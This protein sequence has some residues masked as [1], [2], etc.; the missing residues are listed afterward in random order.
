M[1]SFYASIDLRWGRHVHQ[2]TEAGR[3]SAGNGRSYLHNATW[4]RTRLLVGFTGSRRKGRDW[5]QSWR[6]RHHSGSRDGRHCLGEKTRL[7]RTPNRRAEILRAAEIRTDQPIGPKADVNALLISVLS[8]RE[9][10]S[11]IA[12]KHNAAAGW[13]KT[14]PITIPRQI[15]STWLGSTTS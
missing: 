7:V 12:K 9:R 4:R 14:S 15:F 2:K 13:R 6:F 1:P 10:R 3:A 8:C 11:I 5:R